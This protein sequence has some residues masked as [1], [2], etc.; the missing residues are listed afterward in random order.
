MVK[1]IPVLIAWER[2]IF[3]DTENRSGFGWFSTDTQHPA[4]GSVTVPSAWA[5]QPATVAGEVEMAAREVLGNRRKLVVVDGRDAPTPS[6]PGGGIGYDD[7]DEP[8]RDQFWAALHCRLRYEL[9]AHRAHL[10]QRIKGEG[11]EFARSNNGRIHRL[12][13]PTI[14]DHV[15]HTDV[16]G[17]LHRSRVQAE[18]HG[19]ASVANLAGMQRIDVAAAAQ[20]IIHRNTAPELLSQVQVGGIRNA[21]GCQICH[22][23]TDS[24]LRNTRSIPAATMTDR[25]LGREVFTHAGAACGTITGIVRTSRLVDGHVEVSAVLSFDGGPDRILTGEESLAFGVRTPGATTAGNPSRES[26]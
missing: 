7:Y 19:A 17:I 25:V 14:A 23:I 5:S 16:P 9:D 4:A 22:S 1:V 11:L 2:D 15:W 13:C 12:D 10:T 24:P 18:R 21:R 6:L 20:T 3:A 26:A 8:V